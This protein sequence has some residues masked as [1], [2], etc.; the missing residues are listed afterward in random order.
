[1]S[2]D[3]IKHRTP[4]L[5]L[6]ASAEQALDVEPFDGA[7][8]ALPSDELLAHGQRVADLAEAIAFALNWGVRRRE[9]LVQAA[10][11]HDEGKIM[12]PASIIDKPGT[13]TQAEYAEITRHPTLGA[14]ALKQ[15]LTV[16]QLGWVLHHH[17]RWDG[18][19]Y[20]DRLA[21]DEIPEGAR[22]IA[23]A[24]AWDAMTSVR[25]YRRPLSP[26]QALAECWRCSGTQ[27][28]VEVVRALTRVGPRSQPVLQDAR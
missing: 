11:S 17:E 3:R 4:S 28:D 26:I 20:P 15:Y 1:M 22:I 14:Y 7:V 18:L 6:V 27:F 13:L 10:L 24:D 21:G 23:V 2:T 16:E 5:T 25:C 9:L 8:R 12:L 19:G